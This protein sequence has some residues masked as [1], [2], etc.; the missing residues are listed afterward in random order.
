MASCNQQ[1]GE[2]LNYNDKKIGD[3]LVMRSSC[4][5]EELLHARSLIE[6]MESEQVRLI[7]ELQLMQEENCIYREILSDK[8]LVDRESV[9]KLAFELIMR[10]AEAGYYNV[11]EVI[12]IY[13]LHM[14]ILFIYYI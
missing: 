14:Q 8:D 7:K 6:T 12:T 10:E 11:R 4:P 3:A 1:E 5:P 13:D 9:P 2:V